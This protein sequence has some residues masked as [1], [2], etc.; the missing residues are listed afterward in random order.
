[1]RSKKALYNIGTNVL[2]QF[3]VI[4]YGFVVPKIIIEKFGSDVNGLVS[5][6]T[7]FLGYIAL[8]ESGMGPV[9]KAVLYKPIAKKDKKA[10]ANILN[11]SEKFFKVIA[12]IFVVYL[13][14]LVFF[15]P[16]IVINSFDYFFTAS[17]IIIISI[18]TFAEYYFGMTYKLYLQAE[19]KNYVISL[20]Q[21]VIYIF[22]LLAIVIL[23]KFNVSIQML[24]LVSGLLFVARPILQNIYVKKKYNIDLKNADDNYRL[25]NKWDAL[26]QH[27]AAVIHNNTD[28]A[29]LTFFG[30]LID[31]SIYS[32]YSMVLRGIKTLIQA[33]TG[34]V[35]AALG[36]MIAKGEN[37]TLRRSFKV[38]ELFFHSINTIVFSC[39]IML[40][41]PFISIYTKDITDANYVRPIFA[42]LLVLS[43]FVYSIRLPYSSITL[44]AGHFKET[45][46]GAWV[47][48][49]VNIVLSVVLVIKFGI[50][51]VAI[52]TLVAMIIRTVEFMY[53]S[54]KYILN[55]N[56]LDM[57]KRVIIIILEVCTSI[58]LCKFLPDIHIV[59]YLTWIFKA[60]QVGIITCVVVM[61]VNYVFYKSDFVELKRIALKNLNRK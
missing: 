22:S 18:S 45:M 31:V 38:Y 36:D 29:V 23:A 47:E 44:V 56:V 51:G 57:V 26:A 19:Q 61:L 5:S 35:D 46:K 54:A 24:K 16:F 34:G 33:F 32:V 12:V 42:I 53:H 28:V 21:I 48:S 3:I 43:E 37:E 30:S 50:V 41:V 2:L 59:N 25:E 52:G 27:I 15:Y 8:L 1:M 20:I 14:V 11:A 49:I 60:L 40:I 7:Q 17:L 13:I 6:I 10:I 9:V 58:L 55:I 39:C 4:I